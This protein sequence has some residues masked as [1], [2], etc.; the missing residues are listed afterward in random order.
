MQKHKTDI[1]HRNKKEPLEDADHGFEE[2]SEIE[3]FGKS[4]V[5]CIC[6]G[7]GKMHV[8]KMRWIGRGVPRKFC[9]HCRDCETPIDEE[10]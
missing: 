1:L 3:G 4:K 6:P 7:C 5:E 2:E 10:N 9:Q 8:M